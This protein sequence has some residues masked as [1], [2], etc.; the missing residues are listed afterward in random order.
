MVMLEVRLLGTFDVKYKKKS[1]SISSRPSQSLFAYLILSAG[2]AHR[3]EKLAGLLWPD[4]LEETARDNLRHALWRLRKALPAQPKS[5]YLITDDLSIAFNASADYWLDATQLEKLSESA[6]ADELIAVLSAYGGELL[7]GFYEEWVASEREHLQSIFEHHMARLM[8]LL[9]DEKRWLDILDWGERWIK[10][11]QKPEP[12][13][14]ALMTA[15][16][17]KGDMSKVAATYERCVKSLKELEVEPSEQTRALYERLKAGK[18]NLET[19]PTGAVREKWE[20]SPKTNL[21]VPLTSF[22]GRERE[23]EDVIHLLSSTRLLTLIGS[24]GI[25]KTRL[26]IQAANDLIKSYKEGVWWVELAP[27]IDETL[28]PQAVAQVLGV[29]ESPDQPMIESVKNFLRE[30]Q[31]LLVMDNCEHLIAV[32]AQLADDLLTQC[33]ELSILTTS[34]EAL[35]ITGETTLHVSAL[36]FPVLAHLSQIQNLKEFESIQLFVERAAAARPDLALTQ[37]NAFTV[38]QICHRLDGIPLALELAAARVKLLSLEEIATRLDDR[39]T[40]LTHGSRTALPRHQTLRAAIDWSYDLLSAPERIFFNRL[41][42]FTGGFTL[43]AAEEV[44]TG[45]DVSKSQVIDLLGQLIDK[46]LVTVRAGLEDSE[47]ETRYGMLETIREY[48]REK[49]DQSG[50]TEQVRQRHRDFFIAFVEQTE[51]KL[52]SAEQF[53]WLDRLEVE[54][55]NLRAAWECAIES[56]AKLASRLASALLDFWMMRGNPSEG[57][58]WLAQLLPQ[59]MQ[60]RQTAGRARVL[61]VAGRLSYF[62]RD[63][64]SARQL[65]EEALAIARALGDKKQMAFAL[66]WLGYIANYRSDDQTAEAVAKEALTIYQELQDPLGIVET[67]FFLAMASPGQYPEAEERCISSLA[68]L[69]ELGDNFGV[70]YALNLLGELAR[71]R[72]DYEPARQFYEENLEIL[73]KLRSRAI[74]P[75]MMNLAWVSLY[76]GDTRKAKAL[77]EESLNRSNESGDKGTMTECLT[78]FVGVLVMAGKPEQ[79]ARLIGAAE[80]LLRGMGWTMTAVDQ[81][82]YDHYIAIVRGQLDEGV[83]ER[84]WAEGRSMMFE[85]AIEFALTETSQ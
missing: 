12:A 46:S 5:E 10:L 34:R 16:A 74:V 22:I 53:Q 15:H 28:V 85:Q 29:R 6:S 55:D 41:S 78:G 69:K 1:I 23:I 9:Q 54:H 67:T 50:E 59:T 2:T 63:I 21:P 52:R 24:G 4:S 81:K 8:S 66:N 71:F 48:A 13:Y 82:D 60:W 17:A 31:L 40:L 84:A 73:R 26:A 45:G 42:V 38:A 77:F 65:L 37:Q 64:V 47:S 19:G 39:F 35:G 83:F 33:A 68:K 20:E 51:P 57:R 49:L 18:K 7:P 25:G 75:P 30:K 43:D 56:D 70:A 11:G 36:S 76:G 27:L 72:G 80:S 61:S 14:R 58:E 44:V 32:C 79:A 3:R 62:H